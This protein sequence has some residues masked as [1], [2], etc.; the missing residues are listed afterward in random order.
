[1]GKKYKCF[2]CRNYL[3]QTSPKTPELEK[4]RWECEV[5]GIVVSYLKEDNE[6]DYGSLKG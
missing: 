5:C 6:K 4:E 1:M 3:K 2:Q